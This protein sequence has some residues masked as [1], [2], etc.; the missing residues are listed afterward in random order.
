MRNL[1]VVIA[2]MSVSLFA[3]AKE[4]T[5]VLSVPGMTCSVC[6]ITVKKSLAKVEGVITAESEFDTKTATVTFDDA[7]TNIEALRKATADVGY[8]S[9]VKGQ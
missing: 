6:P 7:L 2:L 9:V 4:Q 3:Q 1:I 5:V 8:P